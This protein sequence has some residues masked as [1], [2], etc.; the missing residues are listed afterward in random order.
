VSVVERYLK[1]NTYQLIHV[2]Y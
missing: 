2:H 1:R